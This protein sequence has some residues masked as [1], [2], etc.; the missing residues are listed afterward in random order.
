MLSFRIIFLITFITISTEIV[1][2][3]RRGG[4]ATAGHSSQLDVEKRGSEAGNSVI[5][6]PE[7]GISAPAPVATTNA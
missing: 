5:T 1:S 3:R 7:P 2:H 4:H 6:Q